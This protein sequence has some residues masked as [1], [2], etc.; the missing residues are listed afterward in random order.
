MSAVPAAPLVRSSADE[1]IKAVEPYDADQ[2]EIDRDNIVQQPRHQQIRNIPANDSNEQNAI[3]DG[4][5]RSA[6]WWRV[7]LPWVELRLSSV[8]RFASNAERGGGVTGLGGGCGVAA[9]V[10]WRARATGRAP[11]AR[12]RDPYGLR[13]GVAETAQPLKQVEL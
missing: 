8:G 1:V 10:A 9:P 11:V 12:R 5:R 13:Q 2:D 6:S 3:D 7:Y 4:R